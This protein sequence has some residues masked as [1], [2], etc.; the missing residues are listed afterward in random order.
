MLAI[1]DGS[2]SVLT[3]FTLDAYGSVLSGGLAENHYELA[4][5]LG[6]WTDVQLGLTYVR[7]RWLDTETGTWLSED[8][9]L[10]E[11]R[12]SYAHNGGGQS[13]DHGGGRRLVF[14][15]NLRLCWPSH[16]L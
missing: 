9:L 1:T 5:G 13:H 3:T 14:S 10:G 6:Y 2:Q 8:P 12:Y 7:A 4:G 15:G 16:L 11:P